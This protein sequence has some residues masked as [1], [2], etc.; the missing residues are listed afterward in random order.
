MS[1]YIEQIIDRLKWDANGLIPVVVQ[2]V[3][4]SQVLMVAWMNAEALRLTF[5]TG[6]MHFWSRSRRE[7]W[8]K[9]ETSV[10]IQTAFRLLVDCD[11]DTL[12]ALVYPAGPACHTG[13]V[14][15]FY[16]D[17]EAVLDD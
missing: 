5:D 7:I 4:S 12:L 6:E 3:H 14:T 10:N 17:L 11:A 9:G 2:D 15:C 1:E 8:N 16:R 13:N